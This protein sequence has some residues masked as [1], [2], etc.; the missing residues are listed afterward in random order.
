[1]N[2]IVELQRFIPDY[3]YKKAILFT[4]KTAQLYSTIAITPITVE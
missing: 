3:M 2:C 4:K 1:M